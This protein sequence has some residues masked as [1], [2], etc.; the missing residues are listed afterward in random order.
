[1]FLGKRRKSN[2][3]FPVRQ[4]L[5]PRA[6]R[7]RGLTQRTH[8]TQ[9]GKA[10]S[11]K[12]GGHHPGKAMSGGWPWA[13][14]KPGLATHSR[15]RSRLSSEFTGVAPPWSLWCIIQ[16]SWSCLRLL[17]H[18]RPCALIFARAR[19]G[20]SIAARIAMIAMTANSSRSV[21]AFRSPRLSRAELARALIEH[22][23][24]LV[25]ILHRALTAILRFHCFLKEMRD[26]VT[27]KVSVPLG[28][29]APWSGSICPGDRRAPQ[30]EQV[31]SIPRG[32]CLP[33]GAE[34]DIKPEEVEL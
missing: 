24:F 25:F 14:Y 15:C 16:Q 17:R 30:A 4:G 9:A 13:A 33:V 26:P 19:A 11:E 20:K 22:I 31:A 10:P 6:N 32:Q 21:K 1:M 7:A 27:T 29:T 12:T 28:S 5:R 8:R 3:D 18:L 2:P 23:L 34:G